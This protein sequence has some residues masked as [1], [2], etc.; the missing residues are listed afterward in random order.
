MKLLQSLFS[1]ALA[2]CRFAGR[3]ISWFLSRLFGSITWQSPSWLTWLGGGFK[4]AT[5][6]VGARPRQSAI[7]GTFAVALLAALA[8]GWWY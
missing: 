1:F 4:Q 7:A 8:G 3:A 2:A 5:G 6:Y